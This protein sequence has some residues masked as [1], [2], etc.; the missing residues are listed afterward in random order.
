M[1]APCVVVTMFPEAV[2]D[3]PRVARMPAPVIA[4]QTPN[5]CSSALSYTHPAAAK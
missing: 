2:A 4:T 3:T 5:V 1:N